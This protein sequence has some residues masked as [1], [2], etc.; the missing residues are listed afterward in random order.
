MQ[1]PEQ[2]DPCIGTHNIRSPYFLKL[3]YFEHYQYYFGGSLLQLEHNGPQNP[4]LIIKAP[5][6]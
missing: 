4:V 1:I 5:I 2:Q 3:P 6:S